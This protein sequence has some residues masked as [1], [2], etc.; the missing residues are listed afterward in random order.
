VRSRLLVFAV[1][2]AA[3]V[4]ACASGALGGLESAS[5]DA[6]YRLAHAA[7]GQ[8]IVIVAIDDASIQRL[9]AW[10]FRRRLHAEAVQRLHA[11]GARAIVYDVQFTEPSPRPAD[12]LALY[13]ALGQAGGGV[14]ATST[15]DAQGRTEVLGGDALLARIHSRAAAANFDT[16]NGLIRT[17]PAAVGKLPSLAATVAAR[18]GHPLP[19]SAFDR[20]G[21]AWIDFRGAFPTVSFADLVA[22]RVPRSAIAGRIAI[23]GATAPTLQD[24]HA[25]PTSGNDTMSGPEVQANAIWTAL[26]GN[27][28]HDAPGWLLPL[29]VLLAAL[30]APA[31]TLRLRPP[32]VLAATALLAAAGALAAQLAFAHGTVA[33]VSTPALALAIGALGAFLSGYAREVSGRRRAA[34]YGR[35]LERKVAERTRELR[36]TQLEVLQRLS[37]AAEHRDDETGA[38]LH[39]M[40]ELCGRLALAA[41]LPELVAEE[42]EQASLLHDVGKIAIPDEILHKPGR[43][44]EGE[45]AIMQTHTTIGAELLAGSASPLLR[46]AEAIALTHHE[47]W[48][49]F[50]YPQGLAGEEIPL[51]GRIAAICDVYDALM[52]ERSYKRAWTREET[53]AYIESERGGHFDPDLADA[54]LELVTARSDR[55]R[56]A[57]AA[58][59]TALG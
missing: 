8:G 12:D 7:P 27:P 14:L 36:L 33:V 26:H 48:D 31:L 16:E 50:G 23:V 58:P 39:R 59:S 40:S 19:P 30:A 18:L 47:R 11:A 20:D 37:A 35:E 44:T 53:L 24:R 4:A 2:A 6:R 29:T 28:L 9:G 43:L 10:P 46:T 54:F 17:Y 42:I 45:R 32:A 13:R 38:H 15:S 55:P 25:T 3:A 34:A 21:D 49:G 52:T 56:P 22:G 41:G 57:P 1:A 51:A 5:V